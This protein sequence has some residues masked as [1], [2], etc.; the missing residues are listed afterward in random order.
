MYDEKSQVLEIHQDLN[1]LRLELKNAQAWL[2]R[3]CMTHLDLETKLYDAED[4]A[5]E[6]HGGANV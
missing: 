1:K 2:D 4:K 3:A 5:I 6:K